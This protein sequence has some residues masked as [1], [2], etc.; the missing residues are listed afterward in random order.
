[1]EYAIVYNTKNCKWKLSTWMRCTNFISSVFVQLTLFNKIV[2]TSIWASCKL[3]ILVCELCRPHS[4][5]ALNKNC[6]RDGFLTGALRAVHVGARLVAEQQPR[7]LSA[8]VDA[9]DGWT[10]LTVPSVVREGQRAL[11]GTPHRGRL[12]A[13]HG[14]KQLVTRDEGAQALQALPCVAKSWNRQGGSLRVQQPNLH[15]QG[16]GVQALQ[17]VAE[18][19]DTGAAWEYSNPTYVYRDT[20]SAGSPV[21]G[22]KL[23]QT[24]AAWEYSNATHAYRDTG[25]AGSPVSGKKMG[26]GDSLRVQQHNPRV[27]GHRVCSVCSRATIS[28]SIFWH[29]EL[30]ILHADDSSKYCFVLLFYVIITVEVT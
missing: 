19:W 8:R 4:C 7:L 13:E 12:H 26:H 30:P 10:T 3:R 25:S 15:V 17:W 5:V 27:H 9:G 21:S 16:Q 23:E 20:G 28:S 24:G 14:I 22:R 1:M 11:E 6:N 2:K 18:R 29:T